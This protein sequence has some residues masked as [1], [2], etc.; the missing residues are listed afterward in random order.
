MEIKENLEK[1]MVDA[2]R[3]IPGADKDVLGFIA[4]LMSHFAADDA[5][6]ELMISTFRAGYC[7]HF[8]HLLKDTFGRGEVCWAAPFGHF[9]WVDDSGVPY[10]AE[11]INFGEQLYNIPESYMGDTLDDFRHIPGK[12]Y[13]SSAS[14]LTAIIRK[15]ETDNNL[16]HKPV[17]E[18]LEDGPMHAYAIS[19]HASGYT[20]SYHLRIVAPSGQRQARMMKEYAEEKMP[21]E[22]KR[23]WEKAHRAVELHHGGYVSVKDLGPA[24]EPEGCGSLTYDAWNTRSD[25]LND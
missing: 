2:A 10:D 20:G 21:A 12:D 19:W 24:N 5:E 4:G 7:W 15:Y 18:Y 3:D 13:C 16:E 17:D 11:G 14:E 25:H 6:L 8:A 22:A 23:A 1:E 9:V